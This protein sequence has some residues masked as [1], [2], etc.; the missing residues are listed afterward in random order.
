M[1]RLLA[2]ILGLLILST[3]SA[4]AEKLILSTSSAD[5]YTLDEMRCEANAKHK[6]IENVTIKVSRNGVVIDLG[7]ITNDIS[8]TVVP[9]EPDNPD[10]PDAPNKPD[11]KEPKTPEDKDTSNPKT[12]D[13]FNLI[14]LLA[15]MGIA[16]G[17]GIFAV[18][19]KR[20]EE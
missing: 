6:L 5:T 8:D 1:K 7:T 15:I 17:S 16:L 20:E 13:N 2:L 3:S 9:D 18:L 10:K 12:G 19:R 14:A 11:D 4:F